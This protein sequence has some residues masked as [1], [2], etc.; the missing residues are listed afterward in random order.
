MKTYGPPFIHGPMSKVREVRS[1]PPSERPPS[2]VIGLWATICG[3]AVHRTESGLFMIM[4]M[5][6]YDFRHRWLL[7]TSKYIFFTNDENAPS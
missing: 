3:T 7:D 1:C 2:N 4:S 6:G 5:S